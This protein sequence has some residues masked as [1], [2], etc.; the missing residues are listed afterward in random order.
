VILSL[1]EIKITKH[2]HPGISLVSI[3]LFVSTQSTI[4]RNNGQDVQILLF[5]IFI[6]IKYFSKKCLRAFA[7]P[8]YVGA[9]R[10]LRIRH[11]AK[12]KRFW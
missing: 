12:K 3:R 6:F 4:R 2:H 5:E 8:I 1:F 9:H 7:L 11:N 10:S